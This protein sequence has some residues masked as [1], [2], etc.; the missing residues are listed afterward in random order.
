MR[1]LDAHARIVTARSFQFGG[2][3]HLE[4]GARDFDCRRCRHRFDVK[5]SKSADE[6][7]TT[8]VSG[9]VQRSSH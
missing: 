5:R 6:V 2:A 8:R 1:L 9:W 3:A 4:I 7:S